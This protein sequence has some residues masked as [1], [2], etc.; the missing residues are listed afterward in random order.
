MKLLSAFC[1]LAC[2]ILAQL[3]VQ[4]QYDARHLPFF[5]DVNKQ[6]ALPLSRKPTLWM[7]APNYPPEAYKWVSPRLQANLVS[8]DGFTIANA[9]NASL[10]QTE[11]WVAINPQDPNNIVAGSNDS[12]YNGGKGYRMTAFV[13]HDGGKT[14]KRTLLP[15]NTKFGTATN[16][17]ATNFDAALCFDQKGTCYYAYG[18]ARIKSGTN[19][20]NGDNY[21]FV[22]TSTNGGDTWSAPVPVFQYEGVT[23]PPFNDKWLMNADVNA[24]SPYKNNVYVSWTHFGSQSQP[25]TYIAFSRSTDGGQSWSENPLRLSSSGIQSSQPAVGPDGTVYVS[26][27]ASG[28]G[29]TDAF[30]RV[31]TNGGTSFTNAVKAQ[32]V[33]NLGVNNS[34]NGRDELDTKQSMRINSAPC[35]DVDRSSG[36]RSGT[37][38]LVQAGRHPVSNITG[39][40]MTKSTDK[41][42]TW[43]TSMRIDSNTLDNDCFFPAVSVDQVTGMVSVFY[44]SSQ[45]APANDGADAYLAVSSNGGASWRRF[46]LSPYT[47][48]YKSTNTVSDQAGSGGQYWGDYS[49]ITS[50][51]GKIYPCFWMPDK[52]NNAMFTNE[53]YVGLISFGPKQVE[54]LAAVSTNLTP[55]QIKLTWQDPTQNK[56]GEPIGDFKVL[57]YRGGTKI[58]DVAK[59]VQEYT[60]NNC[61]DGTSYDYSLI[62]ET[63]NGNQSELA[64]ISSV[65]GGEL[66]PM[67]PTNLVAKPNEN[68]MQLS[69]TTPSTHIDG[70]PFHDLKRIRIYRNDVLIDS[71][72]VPTIQAGTTASTILNLPKKQF[73]NIKISAVGERS[74]KLTES[75]ISATVFSYSGA[76]LTELNATFD[77]T[78]TVAYTSVNYTT[79]GAINPNGSKWGK[80]T[81]KTASPPNCMTD[82]P[83]GNYKINEI[84]SLILAPIVVQPGKQSLSFKHICLVRSTHIATIEYSTDFGA[85]WQWIQGA[86]FTRNSAPQ[87]SGT[88]NDAS[89]VDVSRSLADAT[90]DT[91][92]VRFNVKTAL[93]TDDGW[94]I[95]DVRMDGNPSSVEETPAFQPLSIEAYPNPTG[96][97]STVRFFSERSSQVTVELCDVLGTVIMPLYNGV[98]TTG[99][100]SINVDV[101]NLPEGVYFCR[102]SGQG[103]GGA[104]KIVVAR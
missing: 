81:A 21:V 8:P 65:A 41:G 55:T 38:Y 50:W 37:V 17:G 19:A 20:G 5:L 67:P 62:V 57:V 82:S 68:G 102:V 97:L 73:Y 60:D 85:N 78:D 24:S 48:Y 39:V 100:Q 84:N 87:F 69:W 91:V 104:A 44:Y 3:P 31:S 90:G 94:Y 58:A 2:C 13:T 53:T 14:W 71:V 56:L 25:G 30:V 61:V 18:W 86:G 28:F 43:S 6:D 96:E 74:G 33:S 22:C 101:Q 103:F 16:G 76:P 1:T 4:A 59:G 72:S 29:T 99:L 79:Q 95:D 45:N 98:M 92:Y 40:Y 34:E 70:S 75:D 49:G 54:N 36:S 35:M 66:K 80:Y 47:W 15:D 64:N 83:S 9:S 7:K 11:T 32:S 88:I 46:R 89:W 26:W 63:T 27:R 93:G 23:D 52:T 77:G 42:K 12:E 10:D 51:G